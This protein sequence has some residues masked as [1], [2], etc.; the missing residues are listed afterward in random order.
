MMWRHYPGF[1]GRLV[2]A[3]VTLVALV[4]LTICALLMA[5]LFHDEKNRAQTQLGV[6][7]RITHEVMARRTD[8]ELSRLSV[9]VQ[10]YGFLAALATRDTATI[11][12]AMLNQERRV[13]A[14]FTAL[15]DANNKLLASSFP[16]KISAISATQLDTIR[17]AGFTRYLVN[18]AHQGY[19]VVIIPVTAPG[20][21]AW[22]VAGFA[23]DQ[24]FATAI[25]RLSGT[26]VALRSQASAGDSYTMF[27]ASTATQPHALEKL[28][29]AKNPA[30]AEDGSRYFIRLV[31]LGGLKADSIEAVLLISRAAR[32][33]DY[34]QRAMEVGFLVIAIMVFAILL[35]LMLARNLG[36]PVLQ[37]AAYARAI[38]QGQEVT[39]PALRTGGE[40]VHLRDALGSMQTQLRA[41]E[42]QIRY[43]AFHDDITEL[44]NLHALRD[45]TDSLLK[46]QAAA[47][48]VAIRLNDL[49]DINDTLGLSF[50]DKLLAAVARRLDSALPDCP[51][52]ARTGA[53]E[54]IALL[55]AAPPAALKTEAERLHRHMV[56]PMQVEDIALELRMT[57]ATLQLPNDAAS[58]NEMTRRLNL[59][60]NQAKRLARPVAHY[61]KGRDEAH[62]RELKLTADLLAAI[63]NGGLS[64]HY[65]PK[66]DCHSGKLTQVEALVRWTHPDFG[67]VS[68]EEFVFL[69]ERSGQIHQLTLYV[70]NQVA[71]DAKDWVNTG[72]DVGI[73]I[74]LSAMDLA[75]PGLAERIAHIFGAWHQRMEK[76]TFEV[77]E[78]AIIT[79]PEEALKTLQQLRALGVSLSIDD[80]G[81]GYSSLS[82]L[83]A[84]PVQ[85]LKIDKSFVLKL[86]LEPEDQLIVK[87]TIDMAH[88]LGLSVVA[89]GVENIETWELLRRWGC[90]LGQGYFMSRPVAANDLPQVALKLA[91]RK[92]E[93]LG[94]TGSALQ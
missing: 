36:R 73:G 28:V 10:D 11:Q 17:G 67:P 93:F 5:Y 58:F 34:Y 14:N 15:I 57:V 54:F 62:L 89:E 18:I 59:A 68:P 86:N 78:S 61:E 8:L 32:L 64:M 75:R 80:Y 56:A 63:A 25:A 94:V 30:T 33:Q 16:Q 87:S 43:N 52:I 53:R 76:L 12:S 85:E 47:S 81:T 51:L 49:S 41:R 71:I 27:A 83:R 91:E 31:K 69:A 24:R 66:L 20:I 39:P 1:R 88:G 45:A 79:D 46:A 50:G 29:S 92:P 3:M 72:L 90:N 84:L 23:L 13:G 55:P 74:N 21:R 82:Q 2:I 7:Q 44:G 37:L 48:V 65:Q 35:A 40:L 42:A 60:F 22:L 26:A 38:G 6:A 77:T 9:V 19:E 4:S 70:L